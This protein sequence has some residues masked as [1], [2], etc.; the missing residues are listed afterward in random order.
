MLQD[1]GIPPVLV[2]KK[3]YISGEYGLCYWK[4]FFY[5]VVSQHF[6]IA[7]LQWNDLTFTGPILNIGAS[8]CS[9]GSNNDLIFTFGDG[10]DKSKQQWAND[11]NG[12]NQ[13]TRRSDISC[14]KFG[15]G[16]IAIFAGYYNNANIWAYCAITLPDHTI[17]YI[18]G[19]FFDD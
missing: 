3:L 4:D 15:N 17:L 14:A 10:Y 19:S 2:D 11:T 12:G 7:E 8:M 6:T 13:P 18:G 5:L 9:G 1:L 16:S